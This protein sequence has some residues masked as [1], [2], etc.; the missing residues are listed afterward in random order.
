LNIYTSLDLINWTLLTTTTVGTGS[1]AQFFSSSGTYVSLSVVGDTV[2][3]DYNT[4][5]SVYSQYTDS[6]LPGGSATLTSF[7]NTLVTFRVN[8]SFINFN[9]STTIY[10]YY[11]FDLTNW[12][13][14][15]SYPL[16]NGNF[17]S[18]GFSHPIVYVALVVTGDPTYKDY[19]T[20][21]SVYTI[22][23]AI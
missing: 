8:W 13:I 16:S 1:Y 3:Q 6:R 20:N 15:A 11:S 10:M 23:P 5:H 2:Y 21:F 22:I 12:S 7:T 4:N 18:P 9:P 19:N 14:F 17:T